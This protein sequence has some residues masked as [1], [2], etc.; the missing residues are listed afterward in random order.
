[1]NEAGVRGY[2]KLRQGSPDR[3]IADEVAEGVYDLIAIAA[4]AHGD[5]VQQVLAEVEHRALHVGRPVLIV[6]PT[7]HDSE[8]RLSY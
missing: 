4:E 3:Q 7:F 6:K 5:F 2:L 8:Y 1:L